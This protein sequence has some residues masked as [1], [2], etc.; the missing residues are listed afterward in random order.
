[1][2]TRSTAVLGTGSATAAKLLVGALAFTAA[3]VGA[4]AYGTANSA[5]SSAAGE[6]AAGHPREQT[7]TLSVAA[8]PVTEETEPEAGTIAVTT[9]PGKGGCDQVFTARTVVLN[10]DAGRTL[11]YNW[12]LARWSSVSRSWKTYQTEYSGFMGAR[13]NVKWEFSVR[14]NPGWYR[15]E[16]TVGGAKKP[17]RSDRLLVSC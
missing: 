17:I 8:L 5:P 16:L 4:S 11:L 6:Q 15:I 13:R 9:L 7:V 3:Y 14:D 1:M 12:R 10:P 2:G